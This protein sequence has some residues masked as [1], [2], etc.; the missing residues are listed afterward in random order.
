MTRQLRPGTIPPARR[1]ALRTLTLTLGQGRDAQSALDRVLGEPEGTEAD[2]PLCT[3]LVYGYLRYKGRLDFL[4]STRLS[5]KKPL[6]ARIARALGVALY[7]MLFL[8][9]IPAYAT[10]NWAVDAVRKDGGAGLAKLAN[11]VLR[12]LS[13]LPAE[14]DDPDLYRE[15]NP[16]LE[17]F[18]SRYFSCPKWIVTLWLNSFGRERT[19][20]LLRGSLRRPPVSLRVN[21]ARP[22]AADLVAELGQAVDCLEG[23]GPGLALSRAP[24]NITELEQNGLVSRQSLAAQNALAALHPETWPA[25]ILDACSGRGGK[26]LYLAEQGSGPIMASDVN[27]FRLHGLLEEQERL[28]I[29][30]PVFRAS[31][32]A[33]FPLQTMPGTIL[34]DVPCS[35]LGVLSRRPDSKWKRT[36]RDLK[37]LERIQREILDNSWAQLPVGGK[38]VYLTCTVNARE[39]E[40][41][42]ARFLKVNSEATLE[43]EYQTPFDSVLGEFFYGA[44]IRKKR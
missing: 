28:N 39:N 18:L 35:G 8:S 3:E 41:Q 37:D 29:R 27:M 23:S 42:V 14:G 15:D 13:E 44:T 22:D 38:I 30:F 36:K 7:E 26:S 9:R 33:P 31:A 2:R 43:K 17:L 10:V 4:I 1:M 19:E 21:M 12:S 24:K 11:G 6:P 32:S 34:L 25:P 40:E 16:P 20:L 5:V